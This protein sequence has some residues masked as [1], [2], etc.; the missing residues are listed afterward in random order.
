MCKKMSQLIKYFAV[1]LTAFCALVVMSISPKATTLYDELEGYNSKTPYND[2]LSTYV[3]GTDSSDF[4]KE[5][6]VP[7]T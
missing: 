2:R 4:S 1:A 5:E 7:T 6:S 3:V